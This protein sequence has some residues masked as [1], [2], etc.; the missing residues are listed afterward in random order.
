MQKYRRLLQYARPHRRS[1][2]FIFALT[3]AASAL[4]ALQ[5]WPL[6]LLTDHVLGGK[7]APSVLRSVLEIFSPQPTPTQFLVLVVLSGLALFAL[8]SVLEVGLTQAWTLAGRK[9]VY[10]LAEDLFARLQRRSLVFHSQHSVGDSMSRVAN[11]SWTVYQVMDT[12]LFAPG[13][14]LLTMLL[15]IFLMAHLD[16]TLTVLSLLIAP[17]MVAASFLVGKP[18]RAAAKL[19]RE[20]ESR[21]QSHIQQTL[22][23]IP[24][25]QAFVQE[26]REYDRF[27]RY[28]DAAIAAQQRSTLIGSINSLSSGLISTLGA[29]AILWVGAR[30]VLDGRLTIG[31]ILV[32]L[33]YLTSLQ[34]QTKILGDIYTK[35]QGF[36][37]SVGRVL[38]VLEGDPEVKEKPDAPP[39]R[40]ARG[41]VQIES[42][43]FGYEPNRPVLRDISLEAHPGETL[44]IVGA[45]GAGKSTLVNLVPRFF[46]PWQGRVL[47]DGQDARGVQLKSLRDQIAI[48]L[49]EPYLFPLTMAE[50]IAYSRPDA[51]RTEVE[52]A[53]RAANIHAFIRGLPQGYDT[54]IGERGATLSG[55]ERQRIAIARAL[56]KDAPILILDEPT[57]ALDAETER[58][59][60][61]A[62]EQLME[63]RTTFLIAHRL[64]TIRHADRI[65]VL[66]DGRVAESGTHEELLARGELYAHLQSLVFVPRPQ[67]AS[68]A[69]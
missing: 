27:Q 25:V 41:H 49:Q 68:A 3:I 47:I 48:V 24:V 56:L 11:D 61:G 31:A 22:T 63:G 54:L 2:A 59:I 6:A 9:M 19:K 50:N 51:S 34:S 38:E 18:L 67:A 65:V 57:S 37:A 43:T 53:A 5:P 30:H 66:Q 44:A 42:V 69:K 20:I 7:P 58:A 36:S 17:F 62:L 8:N 10:D 55:G 35:L 13:H 45:T 4:A 39:L 64:S 29:G 21:I 26:E 52:K 60:L 15:M 1:F 12:V 14:A 32:F 16:L 33:V 46:D 40:S 28:A 23:G